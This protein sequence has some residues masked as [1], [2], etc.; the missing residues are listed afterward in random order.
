MSKQ[1]Y[2]EKFKFEAIKQITKRCHEVADVSARPGVSQHSRHLINDGEI[3]SMNA[4]GSL[5]GLGTRGASS[6]P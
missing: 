2:P 4:P 5:A 1:R 3:R 6:L